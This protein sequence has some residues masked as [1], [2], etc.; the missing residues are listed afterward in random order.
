[1]QLKQ[2]LEYIMPMLQFS[3]AISEKK[4]KKKKKKKTS[5]FIRKLDGSKMP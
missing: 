4:K 5:I 3:Y 2:V 1:M